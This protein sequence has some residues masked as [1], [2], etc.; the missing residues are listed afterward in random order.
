MQLQLRVPILPGQCYPPS[1]DFTVDNYHGG[2]SGTRQPL[3]ESTGNAQL[4]GF[5]RPYSRR[6]TPLAHMSPSI[7]T[8]VI[9][10]TQSLG[11]SYVP[12]VYAR[13]NGHH[14]L[15][16]HARRRRPDINPLWLYCQPFQ[17][18]RKKQDEK[19]DKSGQKW[20]QVLEDAFLD[21]ECNVR[22]F[23]GSCTTDNV[24]G[25]LL[26][27]HIGRKKYTVRGELCGRNMLLGKYLWLSYCASCP[28]P[29]QNMF[30]GRKQV[31]SHI[32]VLKNIFK[33]HRCC[34]SN[35]CLNPCRLPPLHGVCNSTL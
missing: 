12:Q 32:Q 20:P 8:P 18:Y 19:D 26:I 5:G 22:W 15:Q 33:H 35:P 14:Q 17:T 1:T 29:D 3:Q 2:S 34:K 10:P 31:S 4:S 6:P 11:S 27:P 28:E 25:L 13:Q 16:L 7:V 23:V 21:G 9:V 24:A 30:R